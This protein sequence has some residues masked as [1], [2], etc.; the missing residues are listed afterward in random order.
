VFKQIA[1]VLTHKDAVKRL[2]SKEL[3]QCILMLYLLLY[4]LILH[5]PSILYRWSLKSTSLIYFPLLWSIRKHLNSG[6]RVEDKI[7]DI[8]QDGM[9]RISR[10]YAWFVII[11]LT[12][13]PIGFLFSAYS[14]RLKY[15]PSIDLFVSS[16]ISPVLGYQILKIFLFVTLDRI[17]IGSWHVARLIGACIT[18][19]L[20]YYARKA[21]RKVDKGIWQEPDVERRI[22]VAAFIRS[23]LGIFTAFCSVGIILTSVRWYDLPAIVIRWFPWL[24][25]S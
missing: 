21:R 1:D 17:E 3:P 8:T 19:W 24:P 12:A 4:L 13:L 22:G 5:I 10:W 16:T 9:E 25:A 7:G 20:Y 14:A 18:I 11:I 15:S 2:F 6:S 23:C